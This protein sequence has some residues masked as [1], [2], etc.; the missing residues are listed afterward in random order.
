MTHTEPVVSEGSVR[1]KSDD[2]VGPNEEESLVE[3]AMEIEEI[4]QEEGNRDSRKVNRCER[5]N[6]MTFAHDDPIGKDNC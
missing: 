5:C 2:E 6:R 3:E 1:K 4:C